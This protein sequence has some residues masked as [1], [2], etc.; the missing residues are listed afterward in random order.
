VSA[1]R[2]GSRRGKRA[3]SAGRDPKVR[4]LSDLDEFALIAR[5]ARAVTRAGMSAPGV[6]LGIGDD[7]AVL[8]AR[9]RADWVVSTDARVEDVHFRWRTESAR[10]VGRTAL[11]AAL[12]DLAAM[13]AR[14]R[15][16]TCSLAA[17][18]ALALARFDGLVAGLLEEALRWGC[19]LVGGNLARARETSLALTVVGEV[20]PG[21]AL[22]R[23]ARVGDRV[24]VTGTLG[25]AALAR[26]RAERGGSKLRRVPTPRLAAGRILARTPG[27][28]GCIDVSDGL[29][30][31]LGHLLGPALRVRIEPARVPRPAGFARACLRLGLDPAALAFGGG[32]DYELLFAAGARAPSAPAF[33]RRLGVRV[34]E[35]GRVERGGPGAGPR[36]FRHFG[37]TTPRSCT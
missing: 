31:D 1:T 12:S 25:G 4:V 24:L 17:P 19:P 23:R 20:A 21:A 28:R 8:R 37:P 7:A 10:T 34:S 27:I 32:E 2:A 30:A 18:G 13:G 11:V 35:L 16:F 36:G 22:R 9:G 29:G 5:V 33:A 3:R 15:G 6:R 14:P 26:A